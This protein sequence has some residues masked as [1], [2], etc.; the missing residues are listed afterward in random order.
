MKVVKVDNNIIKKLRNSGMS[1]LMQS[2]ENC[3]FLAI[4]EENEK[5]I[6]AGGVGGPFHTPSLQIHPDH[7]GKRIG[8]K[9][10]DAMIN[11]VKNRNYSFLLGSRNP[12]N[13][14][15]IK[16]E[17]KLGF[18]PI[19]RISYTPELKKEIVIMILKTRGKK[20]KKLLGFFNTKIGISILAITLRIV[21]PFYGQLFTYP[22]EQHPNVAVMYMI[23]NFEKI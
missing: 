1:E 4:E 14:K 10:F 6:G 2:L 9:L 22:T 21:K 19:F 17:D 7:Y 11:E 15:V 13:I 16:I 8:T 3:D 5:I 20:I 18:S 23:K 12:E